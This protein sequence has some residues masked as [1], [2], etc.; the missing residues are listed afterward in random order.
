MLTLISQLQIKAIPVML[1]KLAEEI[2][3]KLQQF[4]IKLPHCLSK[5]KVIQV[6]PQKPMIKLPHCQIIDKNFDKKILKKKIWK[7][8]FEKKFDKKI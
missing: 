1:S 4:M 3:A 8:N 5:S 2:Q 6:E 7:K